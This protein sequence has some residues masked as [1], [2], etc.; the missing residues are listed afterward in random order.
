MDLDGCVAGVTGGASGIGRALVERFHAEGARALVVADRDAKGAVEVAD[1]VGGVA[2]TCDVANET[3]VA[4]LV[5][6]TVADFGSID[7]MVSNAGYVTIGA[8]EAPDD[9]LRR[10]FDVHVMAHLW[11]ARHA[12]PHM[13]ETGGGYLLNTA[14][15]AGLLTQ[16]GSLHYSITKHAAVS[17]A[18]FGAITY[19]ERGIK[20]AVL[21][22]QAVSTDIVANSPTSGMMLDSALS[23]AAVDGVLTPEDLAKT[24][25]DGLREERYH[26]L[27]H[28]EVAEYARRK[29]DDVDRWLAGMGR[30]QQRLF[31]GGETPADWLT[32]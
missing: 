15:A 16:L 6:G 32:S 17:L 14:S 28:P 19:G 9:E 2:V 20:V 24:V 23:P 31:G 22:P 1:R 25:I 4:D 12:I 8:L 18:E 3:A 27:P 13:V 21:C 10:M 7:L 26:I 30:F 29:G 5:A 11:A